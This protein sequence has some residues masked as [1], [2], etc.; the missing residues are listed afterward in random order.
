[1]DA[2]RRTRERVTYISKEKTNVLTPDI[3]RYWTLNSKKVITL[4]PSIYF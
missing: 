2:V 4:F 3:K 1:M